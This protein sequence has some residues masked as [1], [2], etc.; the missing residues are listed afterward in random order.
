MKDIWT[1]EVYIYLQQSLVMPKPVYI[2]IPPPQTMFLFL[3]HNGLNQGGQ[4]NMES[5][6]CC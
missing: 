5:L 4:I 3:A 6:L 2:V 1:R